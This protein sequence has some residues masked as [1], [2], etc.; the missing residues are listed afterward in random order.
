MAM[1]N[2]PECNSEVS[3]KA[4]KCPK[5]G[6]VLNKPKR[7]IFGKIIKWAFI[8]F[9]LLMLWWM[10]AGVGGAAEKTASLHNGAEQAGA[11]IGT[12][13]GAMMIGGIWLIGGVILG[14]FVLFTKP[15]AAYM[16][17]IISCPKCNTKTFSTAQ[18]CPN[19]GF[20]FSKQKKFHWFWWIGG[21]FVILLLIWLLNSSSKS[22]SNQQ[23]KI[24]K[25]SMQ[26]QEIVMNK[27]ETK[28]YQAIIED[29]INAWLKGNKSMVE[30]LGLVSLPLK[31]TANEYQIEYNKNEVAADQKFKDKYFIISGT[32]K[33]INR[34]MG[35]NYFI[36]FNGGNNPYMTPRAQMAD[37]YVNYLA[38]LNKGNK[39]KLY[40][41]GNGMIV[42]S[43]QLSHCVPI[44]T[45]IT[46][47]SGEVTE[48]VKSNKE[49]NGT[50]FGNIINVA[51]KIANKINP[52]STCFKGDINSDSC[53]NDIYKA[54]N[55]LKI[56]KK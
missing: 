35:E 56:K 18:T 5:C 25:A 19:C 47:I 34:S 13:L 9:N 45:W 3:D 29:D 53:L 23:E 32:I 7:T 42:G 50:N 4:S 46:S 48:V 24:K 39:E 27:N 52:N 54:G 15:K 8:L 37:G 10:V 51:K 16:S 30:E 28:I 43:A 26:K 49:I 41:M 2:C 36:V 20:I 21:F 12:G 44:R 38:N 55:E 40:C 31:I 1:A 11:A 14:M 17:N 6:V 33:S 22:P